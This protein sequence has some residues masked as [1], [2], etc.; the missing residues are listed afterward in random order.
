MSLP[1]P[2]AAALMVLLVLLP[3]LSVLQVRL[4]RGVEVERM[5]A[6]LSSAVS[7]LVLG[8]AAWAL[9][10][11]DGGSAAVGLVPLP[12]GA[13]ALWSGGLV[14]AGLALTAAFRRM[15]MIL[16][17]REA[18]LLR[19]LLPRTG[20]ER[21]AFTGL[22]AAAG[23]GEELAYRGYVIPVLAGLLGPGGAAALSSVVFGVL[24]AYQGP[25]GMART[26]ALGGLL[27][28]GFLASGSLWPPI[29]AH[30]LLDVVLGAALAERM[31]VPDGPSGVG[32]TGDT[33]DTG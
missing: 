12:W 25:L 30:A 23:V 19:S 32:N 4:L 15:G 6:Y 10:S 3:V 1:W 9:G 11:R 24:H 8:G 33:S 27:A 21:A 7:L 29:A 28:W 17:L 2:D 26:A 13:F 31:M 18:P 22:S 5:P 16:G 14:G 20:R